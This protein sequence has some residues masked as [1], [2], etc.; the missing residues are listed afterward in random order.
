MNSGTQSQ[1]AALVCLPFAGAG[2]SFY[3]PWASPAYR[4]EL[5]IV[6]VRL[7]GRERRIGEEPHRDVHAAVDE[8]VAALPT[9]LDGATR[10]VLFGHSLGAVLAYELAVRLAASSGVELVRLFVSGSPPPDALR[11]RRAT[12]LPDEEFL[13]QVAE[14]A[15]LRHEAM[16]DPEMRELI[17]PTLRADVQ[18]HEDYRPGTGE[19]LPVPVTAL[20]GTDDRLVSAEEAM[21]WAK[22]TSRDFGYAELPGS[23][24]YLVESSAPLLRLIERTVR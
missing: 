22:F 11:Q 21:E 19:P 24:M 17:L 6:P 7:P 5:R 12:G 3:L 14:F 2:A 4:S 18:M 23:H 13:A 15:G 9:E 10:V 1:P 8:L 16:D 20:R